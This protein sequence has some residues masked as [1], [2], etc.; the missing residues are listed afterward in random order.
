MISSKC[1]G[2]FQNTGIRKHLKSRWGLG[3]GRQDSVL[4]QAV[5]VQPDFRLKTE[6]ETKIFLDSVVQVYINKTGIK[7][8][9]AA[10]D[11]SSGNGSSAIVDPRALDFLEEKQRSVMQQQIHVYAEQLG[12]NLEA[13]DKVVA[14]LQ[15]RIIELEGQ[16]DLWNIE[17]GEVYASG[18]KPLFSSLKA[19][20]YDSWWNWAIQDLLILVHRI[21]I[22]SMALHDAEFEDLKFRLLNRSHPRLVDTMRYL[23]SQTGDTVLRQALEE[24]VPN[25]QRSL[26][27]P[28]T[29]VRD[30]VFMAP[31]TTID[32]DGSVTYSE[33]LRSSVG[34][35]G[36]NADSCLRLG[37]KS[38]GAWDYDETMSRMFSKVLA[39]ASSSG[40]TFEGK[41][42]LLTSAG[43]GSIGAE[44]LHGFL[45]GG[46]QVIVTSS[47]YSPKVTKYYQDLYA[48]YGARGSR[49]VLLPF[50]QASQ[51]DV[52]ALVSYIYDKDGLSWDLDFVVPFAAIS[53]AGRTLD[54]IGSKSELAHRLMLTN[55]LRLLGAIKKQKFSRSITSRPAQV[56]LPM[57]PNH[58]TFG[59]DGL[60]AESKL[61]L[62]SLF[63]KWNS[64]NWGDY[65]TLCGAIIGWTRGTALMADNDIISEGIE[66]L[67]MRTYSQQE[68]AFNILSLMSPSIL[69]LSM[70]EPLLADLSGGM[71]SVS[72]LKEMTN[73]IRQ[74]IK[75]TSEE[76]QAI[77][78][79]AAIEKPTARSGASIEQQAN[80]E[81]SFPQLPPDYDREIRPLSKMLQGMVDLDRVVVVTG[82]GEVGP[83]GNSRTR[84]R[85]ESDGQLNHEGCIELAWIMGLIK[86][87][88]GYVDGQPYA[89]WLEIA[90]GNPISD[91]VIKNKYEEHMLKHS[92]IRLMESR[93]AD[94][95][96]DSRE[97]LYEI[98]LERDQEPFETSEKVAH[99]LKKAHGENIVISEIPETSQF[100]I[101]LKK[102]AR[103]MVP[104]LNSTPH[105]V[106]GQIPKGWNART[107]GVPEDAINQVDP[108]TLYPLVCAAE[109]LQSAGIFDPCELY[110]YIHV[111]EFGNCVGSGLG[112]STSMRK[113][114]RDRYQDRPAANDVLAES[115]INSG[116]A[117]INML[118]LSAAG[119][120]KTPV[121]ACATSIESLD[122]GY[123]LITSG[124][125]RACLVCG[126][127]DMSK[128]VTDEFANIKATMNSTEDLACGRDP[129]EMSR[130]ATSTR[131]GFVEAEGAG[132]Q[133]ITSASL[134]LEM[135][136]PIHG[137]I[138]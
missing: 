127:D 30:A 76:R 23:L 101:I 19:R 8:P 90:T 32:K 74:G 26:R 135:G 16:I 13:S 44:M 119:P 6:D 21:R 73:R 3:I 100:K 22:G 31:V 113:I 51:Q 105:T 86:H 122:S 34:S 134:A 93:T 96:W 54:N 132:I 9:T 15:E 72:Q 102:G 78:K 91:E 63:E 65:L 64:E 38:L 109:A 138:A 79:E 61:G 10:T 62:E 40:F 130:P 68:M 89:G 25:C 121:G 87:H 18:I 136:L 114:Y 126:Y 116:P 47:S 24:L 71:G 70:S 28:P 46:A 45:A 39:Q 129:R 94:S 4:L 17:H 117:W 2:T 5:T 43:Q 111:S 99:E 57:S 14:F 84:W 83:Y 106:G 12:I 108:A 133:L 92:G 60:Y 52:E 11:A 77:A 53:E 137:I 125:A 35:S 59:N 123:D 37:R 55:L 69:Q 110:R 48:H 67:G 82:F 124:K 97:A 41:T 98:E 1:P 81:F 20:T 7:L 120:N 29:I 128:D 75:Q 80:V 56:V 42:A 36:L 104:K 27:T 50:N 85:M 95:V 66:K 107:Y 88:S 33:H 58:G 131:R 115:F 112:G 118:L 103:I 49:L